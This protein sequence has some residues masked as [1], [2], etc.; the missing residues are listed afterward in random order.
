MAL[1]ELANSHVTWAGSV[2]VAGCSTAEPGNTVLTSG[3][4]DVKGKPLTGVNRDVTPGMGET[5]TA[6]APWGAGQGT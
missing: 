1:E 2:R 4:N 3:Q 6:I 5:L